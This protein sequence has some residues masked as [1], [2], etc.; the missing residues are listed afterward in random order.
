MTMPLTESN[1]LILPRVLIADDH[2]LF[3]KGL[4]SLLDASGAY[5]V[6][7]EAASGV[8]AIE[9][10]R[11]YRPQL[12]VMDLHMPQ[13]DGLSAIAKILK[14]QAAAILVMSMFED[15]SYVL[16]AARAGAKGYMLKSDDPGTVLRA[17]DSLSRGDVF[18]ALASPK[19]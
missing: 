10:S 9:L 12:I 1:V 15:D 16:A 18:L 5:Q 14:E 17:L 2:A 19:R 4:R 13:G 7:A 11:Q 8:E 6:V 3:R